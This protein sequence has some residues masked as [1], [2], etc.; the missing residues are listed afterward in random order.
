MRADH[1]KFQ[2]T[3]S[4]PLY[5]QVQA[6]FELEFTEKDTF[7]TLFFLFVLCNSADKIETGFADAP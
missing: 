4:F 7:Q 5:R 1:N 6:R 3:T 2:L